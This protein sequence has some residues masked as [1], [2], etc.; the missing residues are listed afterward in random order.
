MR[1][2]IPLLILATASLGLADSLYLKDG[3]VVKGTYL[4]GTSRQVRMETADRIDSYDV[5]DVTK[6]EF[7]AAAAPAPPPPAPAPEQRERVQLMRPDAPPPAPAPA[8]RGIMIPAGAVLNVRMIDG[9][10][11]ETSQIGQT[12]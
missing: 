4:G 10:D 11:S 9:V 5:T 7:Q 2:F 1:L 6:I 3:R 12:Y 8:A